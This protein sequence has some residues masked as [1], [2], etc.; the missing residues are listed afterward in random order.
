MSVTVP[1][2]H[3]VV[4]NE[5]LG[6]LRTDHGAVP[7]RSH[8]VRSR[9]PLSSLRGLSQHATSP[10]LYRP[11]AMATH[12]SR[13]HNGS[14][15]SSSRAPYYASQSPLSWIASMA[16]RSFI[17]LLHLHS[18]NYSSSTLPRHCLA[19][20]HGC[21]SR[22]LGCGIPFVWSRPTSR[23]SLLGGDDGVEHLLVGGCVGKV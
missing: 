21:C 19:R 15:R 9:T 18:P 17:Q 6:I 3:S 1:R 2:I 12:S 8:R 13:R 5:P 10:P 23:P 14:P 7:T 20:H 16:P 11:D 22:G 4:V